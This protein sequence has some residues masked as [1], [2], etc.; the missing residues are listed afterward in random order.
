MIWPID[1]LAVGNRHISTLTKVAQVQINQVQI[2]KG[3]WMA[4]IWNPTFIVRFEV[5]YLPT[6]TK[7]YNRDPLYYKETI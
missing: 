7:F 1:D 5:T 4:Q 3:I 2:C 6:A